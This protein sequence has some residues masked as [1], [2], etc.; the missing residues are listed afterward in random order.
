[1]T[2]EAAN[3]MRVLIF[4]I[5][6]SMGHE[7]A[8]QALAAAFKRRGIPDIR[9]VEAIGQ[10]SGWMA[11]AV[12]QSYMSIVKYVPAL[13]DFLYDDPRATAAAERLLRFWTRRSRSNFLRIMADVR[14]HLVI[15]TQALPARI[16]AKLKEWGDGREPGMDAPVFAAVTDFSIHR[17]WAADEIDGYFLPGDGERR[18]LM[19]MGVPSE[20]ISCTGIPIPPE[21]ADP[22]SEADLS[23]ARRAFGLHDGRPTLLLMGGSRGVG[24]KADLMREL[25][26]LPYAVNIL[27]P[28]GTNAAALEVLR[29]WSATSRHRVVPLEYRPDIRMLYALADIAITKP[30]GLTLA[31]CLAVGLP[32]VIQH[33][34]PGQEQHNLEYV[35]R[36]NFA[37]IGANPADVVARVNALLMDPARLQHLRLRLK[38]NSRPDAAFA[39]VDQLLQKFSCLPARPESAAATAATLPQTLC[40]SPGH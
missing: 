36:A 34:L 26:H 18:T 14:P 32:M 24:L 6:V 2:N 38:S 40:P 20:K 12:C 5:R 9:L 37:E 30:G 16:L 15:C 1:M 39:I 28:A 19:S 22:V 3:P 23:L 35:R 11:P 25:E 4:H 7:R 10:S 17:Y 31:E 13:W 27:A 29:R 8:A 21:M 33:A